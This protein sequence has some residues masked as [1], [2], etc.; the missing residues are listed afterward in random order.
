MLVG[1]TAL[2]MTISCAI[3]QTFTAK[4]VQPAFD[5][6]GYG[7][8][9][10]TDIPEEFFE[11]GR[12]GLSNSGLSVTPF[13]MYGSSQTTS[14]FTNKTYTHQ[15]KFDGMAI[16]NGIDVSQYQNVSAID[17]AQ[18]KASGID[19]AFIRVGGRGYGSAGTLYNDSYYTKNVDGALAAGINV[20]LYIYSQAT[21]EAEAVE[22]A[23]FILDRIG[24][25]TIT[26][27]IVLDYEF[28]SPKDSRL[29]AANL[30]KEAATNVCL[31]FCKKIQEA[32]YTPMVYANPDML[33]NHLNADVL[34]GYYPI[35]LANYT[36]A[37]TY[38]GTFSYWQYDSKGKVPGINANV[39]MNFYY[40]AAANNI[41][42]A[43]VTP[44][45]DQIYTGAA[46]TPAP[47]VTLNGTALK[48]GVDYTVAYSNNT[49]IGNA[50]ITL[51]GTGAYTG[52]KTI[53]FRIKTVAISDL[54][55]SAK[56]KNS[57][58]LSWGK[59]AGVDGYE[60]YRCDRPNG[61]YALVKKIAGASTTSFKNT[62]LTEGQRYF[63]KI[64]VYKNVGSDVVYGDY[65]NVVATYTKTSYTRLA[66]P[67]TDTVIYTDMN[68]NS[69]VAGDI[70]ANSFAKVTFKTFDDYGTTWYRVSY[71][72]VTGYM[73]GSQVKIAK[74][75][76]IV[77]GKKI[78]VRKKASIKS[79]RLT[80]LK[81][82]KK[83]AVLK[84]KKV[85]GVTWYNVMYIKNDEAKKGWIS[86]PY[87]KI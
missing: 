68:T 6:P 65:S 66:L 71:D 72:G 2:L 56:K 10:G 34:S 54:A 51:T 52:T 75:G 26:Y 9:S 85:K 84:T 82:N 42:N 37:T 22:E 60:L 59:V 19:F 46:F 24:G 86:A 8:L 79:K 25:R 3:T 13:N 18:V 83:V 50:T 20:G 7:R 87:V 15:D 62:K 32:G 29:R 53:T 1:S 28:A 63:Y 69:E 45:D 57:L 38:P 27:P 16:V 48:A 17:W 47:V 39:D 5:D 43:I 36:T 61:E 80:S 81:K 30:S 44:I 67:K 14:S 31:A 41:A 11:D 76:K 35:W 21:T 4:A 77:K 49:E 33:N 78:N 64:R 12:T 73:H 70:D 58:T 55:M 23:Q 40:V 74:Q